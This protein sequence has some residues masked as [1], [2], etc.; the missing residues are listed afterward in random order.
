MEM[1]SIVSHSLVNGRSKPL[2]EFT[3]SYDG[4]TGFGDEGDNSGTFMVTCRFHLEILSLR[5]KDHEYG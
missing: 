3:L 4:L 5:R 1:L 2:A